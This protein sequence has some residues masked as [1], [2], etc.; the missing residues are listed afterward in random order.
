VEKVYKVVRVEDNMLVSFIANPPFQN[1]YM[2]NGKARKV[3]NG[4]C[5]ST[6]K[7]AHNFCMENSLLTGRI[8]EIWEVSCDT[9]IR[10]NFVLNSNYINSYQIY[11]RKE[12]K[13]P[14]S[15]FT[16]YLKRAMK[17][18]RTFAMPNSY[19]FRY[20]QKAP[21]GTLYCTGIKLEKK[22]L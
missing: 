8:G 13:Y 14:R 2:K 22:V 7:E 18:K 6:F 11:G 5:F 20:P 19:T 16:K 12:I 21:R 10:I 17:D 3:N 15:V 4:M 1:I 9:S